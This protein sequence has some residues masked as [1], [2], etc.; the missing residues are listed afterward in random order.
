M[1]QGEYNELLGSVTVISMEELYSKKK[2]KVTALRR[3]HMA[4]ATVFNIDVG[5]NSRVTI[6]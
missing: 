4:I 6:F 1:L 3:N 5:E 2:T